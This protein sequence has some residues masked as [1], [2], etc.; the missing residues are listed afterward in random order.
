MVKNSISTATHGLVLQRTVAMTR[1]E[2]SYIT[3]ASSIAVA[4]LF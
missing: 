4:R 2:T 1:N 3:L